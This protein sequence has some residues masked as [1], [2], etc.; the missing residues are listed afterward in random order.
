[1]SAV[2]RPLVLLFEPHEEHLARGRDF[3]L[4]DC[5]TLFDVIATKSVDDARRALDDAK[6]KQ[7]PVALLL[8][9]HLRDEDALRE[10]L[11]QAKHVSSGVKVILFA[12]EVDP[13]FATE[14]KR[15]GLVDFNVD[16]P[17]DAPEVSL[18]PIVRDALRAWESTSIESDVVQI[19]G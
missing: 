6:S 19:V 13:Q 5:A 3:L 4:A 10:L 16:E 1:M 14:A 7:Q 15:E 11:Q 17:W 8:V 18:E 12:D 2:S 9:R